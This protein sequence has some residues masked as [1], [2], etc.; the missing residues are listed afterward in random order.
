[1]AIA[2]VRKIGRHSHKCCTCGRIWT[3]S[4]N[5]L[6]N[7]KAHTCRN[8]GN[9]A[10]YHYDEKESCSFRAKMEAFLKWID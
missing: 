2:I 5:R 1:M 9:E 4:D 3:H 8:C 6:D 7:T 10:W